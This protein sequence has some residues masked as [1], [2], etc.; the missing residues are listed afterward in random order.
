MQLAS[1]TILGGRYRI[2]EPLSRRPLSTVHLAMD[3]STNEMTAIKV[4]SREADERGEFSKRFRREAKILNELRNEHRHELQTLALAR[5]IEFGV[6]EKY[7][8]IVMEFLP[9]RTVAQLLKEYGPFEEVDCLKIAQQVGDALQLTHERGIVHRDLKPS[10][11]MRLPD[12]R[13]KLLDFGLALDITK[14]TGHELL[15]TLAYLSPE[16]TDPSGQPPD[17]RSDIYAL[18]ATMYEMLTGRPPFTGTN[19]LQL[20]RAIVMDPPV[21][22]HSYR[23]GILPEVEAL[24]LRCM[25]KSP[26]KR[27]Q[28]P[29]QL[30]EAIRRTLM[31]AEMLSKPQ[32]LYRRA[33]QAY[34]AEDW[35]HAIDLC[36]E[37]MVKYPTFREA[38]L[39]LAKAERRL[40]EDRQKGAERLLVLA[41]EAG[42]AEQWERVS[43]IANQ[44]LG[45]DPQ[46]QRARELLGEARNK[47]VRYPE[48]VTGEGHH[49]MLSKK[50]MSIGRRD[51][52]GT[53]EPPEIDLSGESS[54]K[55]VSRR[56]ARLAHESGD[57]LL[58]P[59]P[60]TTNVTFV[61]GEAL[62]SGSEYRLH[63]GDQIKLGGVV[64][65]FHTNGADGEA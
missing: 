45:V 59:E 29:R 5:I 21:P 39:L 64:L 4:I 54:G 38:P 48:L 17:I 15:G 55:T 7:L 65:T 14:V 30:V 20:A 61:N 25:E 42:R 40:D 57:W 23:E 10:N 53:T 34:R 37:L 50:N 9:G 51:P 19:L 62:G 27:F 60:R 18:G 36:N 24:V 46:N 1:G 16:Q 44:L 11:I 6:E 13:V 52:S 56:H 58:S 28:T 12:G 32:M 49:Y 31:D 47:V 8:Y 43:E 3:Q 63:D 33:E 2:I 26:D 41:E 22:L 35:T